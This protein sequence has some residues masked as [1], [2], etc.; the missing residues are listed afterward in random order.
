MTWKTLSKAVPLGK[1][2]QINDLAKTGMLTLKMSKTVLN[3]PIIKVMKVGS[4]SA[5]SSGSGY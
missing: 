3:C 4:T 2:D 1:D 5:S